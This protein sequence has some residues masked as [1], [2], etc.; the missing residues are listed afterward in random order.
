MTPGELLAA[1]LTELL[2]AFGTALP[3]EVDPS[4]MVR[5]GARWAEEVHAAGRDAVAELAWAWG[6]P[7]ASQAIASAEQT[8][9]DVLAAAD[10][11][12]ALAG[13]ALEATVTVLDGAAELAR[14]VESFVTFAERSGPAAALPQ[15][16][17]T[18]LTVAIDHLATGLDVLSRVT[19]TLAALADDASTLLPAESGERPAPGTPV[20]DPRTLHH[21]G[22]GIPGGVEVRLPDGSVSRA[23]NETAATAVRHALAQQGTPYVWGGTTPG[24]GLDCSGLTQ[25]AYAEAGVDLPRLAQEQ[26][27]GAQVHPADALPG[28]LVVWDGHVAMVIGNGMMVE[29]GDPVAVTPMRTTNSGMAFYGVYR[30]T[31]T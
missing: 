9:A 23:P 30:P 8:L 1:P 20:G 10:R 26:N 6:G 29:A 5:I 21:F 7:A 24:S 16:G 11:G 13:I 14:L 25:Y 28:D 31:G 17:F 27:V 19:A 15:G 2:E 22:D 4:E 18:L 3:P 12:A